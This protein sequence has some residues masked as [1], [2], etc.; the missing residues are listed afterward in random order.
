MPNKKSICE[1]GIRDYDAIM[2]DNP[3][4]VILKIAEHINLK[5]ESKSYGS[6]KH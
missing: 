3:M 4:I 1:T 2:H 5:M 6:I